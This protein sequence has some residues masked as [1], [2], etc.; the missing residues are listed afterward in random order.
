MNLS[1]SVRSLGDLGQRIGAATGAHRPAVVAVDRHSSSG[2]TTLARRLVDALPAADVLHTDDLAWH[3]G[4]FAWDELLVHDV[5]P[6][7]GTG[8]PLAYRP[9][10]WSARDRGGAIEL[11]GD[12]DFLVIEGVGAS[13][14]SVRGA[15]DFT[16]WVE[17]D[18]PTRLARDAARTAAGEA[19]PSGY[20]RWMAEENAYVVEHRPWFAAD[21]LVYG[22]DSI[23][24][25]RVAEVVLSSRA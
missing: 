3:Q 10:A 23:A 18:E 21:L 9:P 19:S 5:L 7:V 24:H 1:W 14:P 6:V 11:A 13:Q 25:D 15:L 2:K 12:L 8:R 16:I 22:G 20:R 17:T 4:V